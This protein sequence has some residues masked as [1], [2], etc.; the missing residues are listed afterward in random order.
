MVGDLSDTNVFDR[1]RA[2][3]VRT[4]DLHAAVFVGENTHRHRRVSPITY[5]PFVICWVELTTLLAL[6][7][8]TFET[9]RKTYRVIF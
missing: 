4:F 1:D 6:E 8:H 7:K 5:S 2:S 3:L 9:C